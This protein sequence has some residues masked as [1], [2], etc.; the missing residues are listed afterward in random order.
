[1]ISFF[2]T[3]DASMLVTLE[4]SSVFSSICNP[5]HSGL[6]LYRE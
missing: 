1:L 3:S 2:I 6:W 4:W 5:T